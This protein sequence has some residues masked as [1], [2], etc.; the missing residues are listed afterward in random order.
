[1]ATLQKIRDRFGILVAVFIGVSLLSFIVITGSRNS[2]FSNA[3]KK[4]EV[5]RING[6]SVSIR[7]YQ[8]KID[9]LT[10][11]YKLS[12][13]TQVTEE[14]ARKIREQVWEELVRENVLAPEYKELGISVSP[15][16]LYD[17][18]SGDNPHPIVRQL[19]TDPATGYFDRNRLIN[20]IKNMQ[21]EQKEY[22]L[23]FEKQIV[24]ERKITKLMNLISKGLYPTDFQAQQTYLEDNKKASFQY[25]SQLF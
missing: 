15:E 1:M 19:F 9:S 7:A 18:V 2:I 8:S 11:I 22:W 16:E 6:K 21:G 4:F 25:I 20:F 12:G 23:Y 5:A 3:S 17:L 14:M 24:N 13:N 10:T